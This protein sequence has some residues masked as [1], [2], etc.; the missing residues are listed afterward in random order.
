MRD[1]FLFFVV[2]MVGIE[3]L[4]PYI[5]ASM[6]MEFYHEQALYSLAGDGHLREMASL[7]C[8]GIGFRIIA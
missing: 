4:R 5:D 7:A 1:R 6:M 8:L 2:W 3:H